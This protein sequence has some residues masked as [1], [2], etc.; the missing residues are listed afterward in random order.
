VRSWN[1]LAG[2]AL[3][4]AFLSLPAVA[5]EDQGAE[6]SPGAY[7]FHAA[8]CHGCHTAKDGVALAGG[9]ALE[10]PF[11]TFFSPNITPDPEHGIGAW[12]LEDFRRAMR[13]GV[14]PDGETYYPSFPYDNFTRMSDADIAALF[15]Y[16]MAQPASDNAPPEHDLSF[17]YNMRSLLVVWR[18]LYF[19]PGPR[20]DDGLDPQ[21][22]RGRYLADA[23]T[24]CG[25]C[26]TPRTMLG[27]TDDDLYLAGSA[28]GAEGDKVPNITPDATTGI[29]DWSEGDLLFLLKAGMMPDGDVVSGSMAEVVQESTRNYSDEDIAALIAWLRHIPAIDNKP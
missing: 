11:G 2:A 24:H 28:E 10:T 22:A 23:L 25:A 20:P 27:G 21:L 14:S 15:G 5:Q 9:R 26:H 18:W 29:G 17:P 6:D 13:H 3:A 1:R 12:S 4:A 7:V 16:L 19:E 8:G